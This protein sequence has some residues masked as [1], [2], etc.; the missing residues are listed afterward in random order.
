MNVLLC[1]KCD[2]INE[3]NTL[4]IIYNTEPNNYYYIS[5]F[6]NPYYNSPKQ[7]NKL[8]SHKLQSQEDELQI[9]EYP[10]EQK[11]ESRNNNSKS[12]IKKI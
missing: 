12:T 3:E 2:K 1:K 11:R 5:T 6:Y 10:Y 8:K 9:I 4:N 7:F